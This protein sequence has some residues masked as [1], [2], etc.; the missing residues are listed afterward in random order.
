LLR[1]L[2]WRRKTVCIQIFLFA[3]NRWTNDLFFSLSR[4]RWQQ[5]SKKTF[6]FGGGK[7]L[8]GKN[9][10]GKHFGATFWTKI[11]LSHFYLK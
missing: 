2:T 9:F 3:R 11:F 8:A 7:I 1:Q 5:A 10:G 4:D 6:D